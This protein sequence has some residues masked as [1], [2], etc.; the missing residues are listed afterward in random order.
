VSHQ[1]GPVA[2]VS[3]RPAT[4]EDAVRFGEIQVASWHA[5]LGATA[6]AAAVDADAFATAWRSAITSPPS[7][8]HR[9]LTACDGPQVVGFVALA[10]APDDDEA[11]EIVALEVDPGHLREGHGSRLLASCADILRQTG[12]AR[13]RTWVVA[14]DDAREAFLGSAGFAPSGV[15]RRLDAGDGEVVEHLWG[16]VL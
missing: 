11:A 5:S 14:D 12:A 10:P 1:H 13:V 8:K 3:V 15:R 16:A 4:P 9:T 2:D 7:A 6:A